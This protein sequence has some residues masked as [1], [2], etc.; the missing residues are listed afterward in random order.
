MG[1]TDFVELMPNLTN[2]VRSERVE[3]DYFIVFAV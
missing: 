2:S 3:A 1:N